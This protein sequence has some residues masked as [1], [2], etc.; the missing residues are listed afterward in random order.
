MSSNSHYGQDESRCVS[1]VSLLNST[2]NGEEWTGAEFPQY[3]VQVELCKHYCYD[4]CQRGLGKKYIM[5]YQ[6]REF[7]FSG[8]ILWS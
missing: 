8:N 6:K 1:S 2:T 5:L 3:P 7:R 4:E